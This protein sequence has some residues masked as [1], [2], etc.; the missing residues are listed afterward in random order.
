MCMHVCTYVYSYIYVCTYV[1]SYMCM[2]LIECVIVC[3]YVSQVYE[4]ILTLGWA[5]LQVQAL[6]IAPSR[7]LVTQLGIVADKL[8]A[9]SGLRAQTLIGGANVKFQI[10]RLR[11][12][13]PQVSTKHIA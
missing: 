9:D 11:E 8:F 10:R 5:P 13:R 6:I 3:M 7:E 12:D 1:Y 4:A 2:Y